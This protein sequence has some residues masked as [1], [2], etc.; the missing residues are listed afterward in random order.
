M[1]NILS[2]LTLIIYFQKYPEYF[3]SAYTSYYLLSVLVDMRDILKVQGFYHSVLSQLQ[4]NVV[5]SRDGVTSR[6]A[7]IP[8]HTSDFVRLL[9]GSVTE[10]CVVLVK[11]AQL[12]NQLNSLLFAAVSVLHQLT[13]GKVNLFHFIDYRNVV[14]DTLYSMHEYSLTYVGVAII[15]IHHHQKNK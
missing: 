6:D 10:P 1:L 13:A 7:P 8:D 15:I 4:Q 11:H 3:I 5:T 14:F 12:L 9:S 2:Q